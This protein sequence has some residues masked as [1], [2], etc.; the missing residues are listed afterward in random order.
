MKRKAENYTRSAKPSSAPSRKRLKSSGSTD[1]KHAGDPQKS[2]I[3]SSVLSV[4]E[5]SFPRGGASVLTPLEHRQVQIEATE[6]VLF[7][8]SGVKR[9]A[10]AE[11]P[12]IDADGFPA[13]SKPAKKKKGKKDG[14]KSGSVR[15]VTESPKS[16][17]EGLSYS[18]LVPGTIVLGRIAQITP[19]DIALTI[20]NNLTGFVP[21][22]AISDY[23]NEKIEGLLEESEGPNAEKKESETIDRMDLK[24][25]FRVGQYLRA[26]VSSNGTENSALSKRRIELSINPRLANDGISNTDLSANIVIQASVRSVEDHGLVMDMGLEGSE[27]RG[28][29]STTELGDL[30]PNDIDEGTVLLCRVLLVGSNER[31]VKLSTKFGRSSSD[32]PDVLKSTSSI[33][34]FTPG[35]LV[36]MLV[37][38][39]TDF[40]LRG[41]IM[42]LVDVTADAIHSGSPFHNDF[43]K[44][45]RPG[46]KTKARILFAIP[47]D[48]GQVLGVSLLDHVLELGTRTQEKNAVEKHLAVSAIVAEAIVIK[49][50]PNMG[51]FL[52]LKPI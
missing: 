21:L 17:I 15:T 35:T 25:M 42:G 10:N 39:T 6:D 31:V 28:F 5:K 7:E 14:P 26:Y 4:E 38:E 27:L 8:Q 43:T 24:K 1:H 11:S 13:V 2:S 37:M 47:K 22:T 32:K 19:R 16:K 36:E 50:Q 29:I 48:D 46:A 23:L 20:P 41:N 18:R 51:L 52:D 44:K 33:R 3:Q 40:G 45:Y 12:G 30:S 49:V 34:S 9:P